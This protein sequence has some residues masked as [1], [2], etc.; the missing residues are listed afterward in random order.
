M[1]SSS[2]MPFRDDTTPALA[3][4]DPLARFRALHAALD[5]ER[6]VF[7]NRATLRLAAVTLMTVPGDAVQLVARVRATDAE[8]APHYEH[9]GWP[10]WSVDES[11]RLVLAATLVRTGESVASFVAGSERVAALMK[12]AGIRWAGVYG[13]LAG[14]V[15]RR[16][17]GREPSRAHVDRMWGIHAIMK[18][19]HW[20]FTGD[21]VTCA[22][23]IGKRGWEREI[24]D[25]VE[26]IYRRL[27]DAPKTWGGNE[28][29]MAAGVLA[30]LSLAPDE[31]ADR[32]LAV[33]S[34]LRAAGVKVCPDEYNEVAVLTFVPRRAEVIAADVA[35]LRSRVS[36]ELSWTE[37]S[38]ATS[39]AASLAFVPLV[40]DERD[41][42]VGALVG[43]LADAKLLSIVAMWQ[44][45]G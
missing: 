26:A 7:W 5:A 9:H 29:Q 43:A 41:G 3:A 32:F 11:L 36:E 42:R 31:A 4:T 21:L 12:E 16:V 40:A 19:H 27:A 1:A 22:M 45:V 6:G 25:H 15:L 30:L 2:T 8:L 18:E 37:T 10:W 14:L 44:A 33:A 23:L 20:F 28:L 38:M 39:L 35:A 13:I 24:A 34:A 17:V